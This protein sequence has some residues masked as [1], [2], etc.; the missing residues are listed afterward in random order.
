MRWNSKQHTDHVRAGVYIT[1][2]PVESKEALSSRM[3]RITMKQSSTA[4]SDN[5]GFLDENLKNDGRMWL[6]INQFLTA[7]GKKAAAVGAILPHV[8]LDLFDDISNKTIALLRDWNVIPTGMGT[9]PLDIMR[10]YLRQL[11]YKMAVRYAWDT[12]N[13]PNFQKKF[14]P[15]QIAAIQPFLYVTIEQIYWV[16]TACA[17]E[18]IDSDMTNVLNAMIAE[19]NCGYTAN[20][21]MYHMYET[22]INNRIKFKIMENRD[23]VAG[24]A[25]NSPADA[26][27][28]DINY[29]VL[30]GTLK[31][32][33]SRVSART[34]PHLTPEE[35]GSMLERL[36]KELMSPVRGGYAAQKR[37]T[38]EKWHRIKANGKK[39]VDTAT[40]PTIY[41]PDGEKERERRESDVPKLGSGCQLSVVDLSD[42]DRHKRLYFTP[43][44][45]RVVVAIV[46]DFV[47][48]IVI[49][50]FLGSRPIQTRYHS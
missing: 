41:N 12:P 46:I 8:Q 23:Y 38:F 17:T 34:T 24:G 47:L 7:C 20:E 21:S 14:S 31:S 36:E 43:Q 30:E 48:A 13:S 50:F 29:C 5:K 18:Y 19:S 9:R 4:A 42:V 35:V 3:Y 39:M 15:E 26:Y 25:D 45:R 37:G 10:P 1:N 27:M 32:I 16:W 28:I 22:D 49:L 6:Q 2:N 33:C 11:V 40:V 44:V